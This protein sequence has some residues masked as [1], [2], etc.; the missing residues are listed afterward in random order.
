MSAA[1]MGLA[2]VLVEAFGMYS[3]LA[4]AAAALAGLI[5]VAAGRD[6]LG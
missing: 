3:Y 4:M 2:G 1:A 6:A 5:L